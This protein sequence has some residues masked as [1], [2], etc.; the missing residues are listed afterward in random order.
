MNAEGSALLDLL[1]SLET[2]DGSGRLQ[3][4]DSLQASAPYT[5]RR[6]CLASKL[7]L[8]QSD[9]SLISQLSHVASANTV[10]SCGTVF[11]SVLVQLTSLNAPPADVH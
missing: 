6:P 7:S 1:E 9:Q 5:T 10:C 3:Q 8:P 4:L 11:T 2:Q